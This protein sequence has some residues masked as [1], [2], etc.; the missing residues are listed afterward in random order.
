M[1][2]GDGLFLQFTG[3]ARILVQSRGN[4]IRESLSREQMDEIADSPVG[5]IKR[6]DGYDEDGKQKR[7]EEVKVG[8]A[9]VEKD[10]KVVFEKS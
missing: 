8:Y 4:N 3:P 2:R 9:N 1:F 6:G 5:V 7:I 10:G